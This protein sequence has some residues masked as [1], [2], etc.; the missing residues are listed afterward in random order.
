MANVIINQ[1]ACKGCGLCVRACPK[2]IM[3]ISKIKI[4]SKG[5]HPSE[6]NDLSACTACASCA[7]SCPDVCIEIEK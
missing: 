4:N 6:V 3:V 2:K 1:D 7:R 5:Y